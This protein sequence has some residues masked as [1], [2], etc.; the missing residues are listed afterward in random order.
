MFLKDHIG[1]LDSHVKFRNTDFRFILHS[2]SRREI[3][4]DYEL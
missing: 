4:G 2:F 1:I 3:Q